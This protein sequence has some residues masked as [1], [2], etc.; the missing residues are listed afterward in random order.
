[1]TDG[2]STYLY[3]YDA[4]GNVGQ[5][6]NAATGDIAAHYEYDPFG[7]TISAD[8]TL[9]MSNPFRFST[10]YYD[11]RRDCTIMVTDTTF[12]KWGGGCQEIR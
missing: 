6:V 11:P 7:K 5:L 1:M 9:A 8:G 2:T 3:C 4:N 10:K 12:L